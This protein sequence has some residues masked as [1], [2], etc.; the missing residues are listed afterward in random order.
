MI[1]LGSGRI[2]PITCPTILLFGGHQ[3]THM[4]YIALRLPGT[5]RSSA[6]TCARGFVYFLFLNDAI[7]PGALI[8]MSLFLLSAIVIQ[9][10]KTNHERKTPRSLS[11]NP[12]RS[13]STESPYLPL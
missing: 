2:K 11:Q 5:F 4:K 9:P 10:R 12:K 1:G 8:K 13:A 3:A 6:F 7:G